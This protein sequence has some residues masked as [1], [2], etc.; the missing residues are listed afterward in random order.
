MQFS[1]NVRDIEASSTLAIAARCRELRALGREVLDLGI[2]EPDFRTPDF[3]A[4]AGIASIEQGFTQYPPVAGLPSL[5][6]AI[7]Q[8]ISRS[9]GKSADPAGVVVSSGAKQSLFNACF[10]LFGPGDEVLLPVP[11][12]TSYPALIRLA[13]AEPRFIATSAETGFRVTVAQLESARTPQVKGLILNSPSNPT[14]AV[15]QRT[16]LAAIARWAQQH[17][18]WI[19]SDEIYGRICFTEPRAP[20]LLDVTDSLE[21]AVIID[22]ASKAFAMTGWRLGYSFTTRKLAERLTALQSQI[23]SGASTPAQHAAAAAFGDHVRADSAVHA[24]AQVF[25]SRREQVLVH[26]A[27]HA[28]DIYCFPPDGAFYVFFRIDSFFNDRTPDSASFCRWVL[29]ETDVAFVPGSAF[30][31]DRYARMSFAAPNATLVE[32][33]RRVGQLVAPAARV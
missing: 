21:R 26:F 9:T 33:I 13:R 31:E 25:A 15:Y 7:A 22:G 28:P 12:W 4:E 27:E 11:Y 20:S 17:G 29:D 2:G 5:R 16:E 6:E 3:I 30:G 32:A 19:I 8:S 24:M 1:E 14:G 18:I 10:T 23:T